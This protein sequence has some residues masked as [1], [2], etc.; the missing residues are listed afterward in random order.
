MAMIE[1]DRHL[2]IREP[3]EKT[4][5]SIGTVH[6][7]IIKVE[8]VQKKLDVLV[9]HELKQIH[10]TQRVIICNLQFKRNEYDPFLKRIVTDDEKW[11]VY[12]NFTRSRSV[13]DILILNIGP[14][15]EIVTAPQRSAENK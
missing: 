10:L 2:T 1:T 3:A 13:S 8:L 12:N 6:E 11:I 9:S 4:S 7:H 14:S 15:L 5:A